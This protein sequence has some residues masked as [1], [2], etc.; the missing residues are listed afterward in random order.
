[1]ERAL[2]L[3]PMLEVDPTSQG[4]M[5]SCSGQNIGRQYLENQVR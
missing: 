5:A 1:M 3:N 2:I 4:R